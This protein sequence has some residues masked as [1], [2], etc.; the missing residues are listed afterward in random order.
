M[1]EAAPELKPPLPNKPPTTENP[2]I[3]ST[4][5][6]IDPVALAKEEANELAL[7]RAQ[8]EREK[9]HTEPK[10]QK[11][12]IQTPIE[13]IRQTAGSVAILREKVTSVSTPII[14]RA[15]ELGDRC[16]GTFRVSHEWGNR[17]VKYFQSGAN[18][19][20]KEINNRSLE[21]QAQLYRKS[22]PAQEVASKFIHS[23]ALDIAVTCLEN[24]LSIRGLQPM[25]RAVP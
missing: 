9:I 25:L 18:S 24:V 12:Q 19:M 4:L 10:E 15:K 23:G 6:Q 21:W 22:I 1:I 17:F 20:K 13:E 7:I 16:Q 11:Q 8:L 3:P 5:S 2:T 14:E